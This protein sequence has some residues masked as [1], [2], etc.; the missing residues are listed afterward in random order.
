MIY[1]PANN[2]RRSGTVAGFTV[3]ELLLVLF[4]MMLLT[5]MAVPSFSMFAKSSKLDQT[6]KVVLSALKQ[7]RVTAINERRLV[8][9]MFGDDFGGIN[10]KPMPGVLPDKGHIEIWTVLDGGTAG[11]PYMPDI[12]ASNH[13][14]AA[15]AWYPYRF[16]DVPMT[17]EALTIPD[18]VR[19]VVGSF[20]HTKLDF[21]YGGPGWTCYKKDAMGEI[22]RH[23]SIFDQTGCKPLWNGYGGFDHVL[24]FETSTGHHCVIQMTGSWYTGYFRPKVICTNMKSIGGVPLAS[25][26]DIPNR[27]DTFPSTN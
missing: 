25:P 5:V 8:A 10:P 12:P 20:D 2:S 24:I 15:N 18:G 6:T 22:L 17:P 14:G 26:K 19:V 27:I 13:Y 4:I 23:Q 1:C 11:V 3:V 21:N 7:A 16:K 9:V